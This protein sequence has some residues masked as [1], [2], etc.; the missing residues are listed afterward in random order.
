[1]PTSRCRTC[2]W[3]AAHAS[4]RF[5]CGTIF[6]CVTGAGVALVVV[7]VVVDA[8]RFDRALA[9]AIPATLGDAAAGGSDYWRASVINAPPS[10][11]CLPRPV[12]PPM[13]MST[14]PRGIAGE[15][16]ISPLAE[17]ANI[18]AL[19]LALAALSAC[20]RGGSDVPRDAH[21]REPHR[22][23]A[24]SAVVPAPA[25]PLWARH[26]GVANGQRGT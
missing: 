18:P 1:M 5:S 23:R 15:G 20:K 22:A 19:K 24:P 13:F 6:V 26:L 2:S 12:V 16:I 21:P 8:A 9:P 17:P 11:N 25:S 14:A 7:V 3:S 4:T 10:P